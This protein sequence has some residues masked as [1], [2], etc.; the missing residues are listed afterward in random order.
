MTIRES[1]LYFASIFVTGLASTITILACHYFTRSR[2]KPKAKTED[3]D[4]ESDYRDTKLIPAAEAYQSTKAPELANTVSQINEARK[5]G[6]KYIIIHDRQLHEETVT[7]LIAVGYDVHVI[8]YVHS[9][10][11]TTYVYFNEQAS[12]KLTFENPE[13]KQK[14][15]YSISRKDNFDI[16]ERDE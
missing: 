16:V 15:N 6:N 13:A 8:L 12:G 1:I 10:S 9:K 4:T 5:K 2:I 11:M 3:M 14:C 7:T